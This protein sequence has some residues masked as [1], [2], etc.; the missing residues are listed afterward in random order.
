MK[1]RFDTV[2]QA[3][4]LMLVSTTFFVVDGIGAQSIVRGEFSRPIDKLT[5]LTGAGVCETRTKTPPE[6]R[7]WWPDRDLRVARGLTRGADAQALGEASVA[8]PIGK[9]VDPLRS[10]MAG[11]TL[12]D[13]HVA[14]PGHQEI[15]N[16]CKVDQNGEVIKNDAGV[17]II[18]RVDTMATANLVRIRVLTNLSLEPVSKDE[19]SATKTLSSAEGGVLN[20]QLSRFIWGWRRD[21][22]SAFV[23]ASVGTGLY[24]I[25]GDEIVYR[26]LPYSTA[27]GLLSIPIT[28]PKTDHDFTLIGSIDPFI[29]KLPDGLGDTFSGKKSI[30]GIQ[31]R[32]AL[33]ALD[34]AGVGINYRTANVTL[35]KDGRL[36]IEVIYLK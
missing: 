25:T 32:L 28:G 35:P 6:G 13:G 14:K 4:N 36:S 27:Q 12:I 5:P 34:K 1:A 18:D 17:A 23:R 19:A 2:R 30:A 20:V 3:L 11:T 29:R 31:Y 26:A 22:W 10:T 8:L 24:Q 16:L 9:G 21:S 7:S 15:I 33:I